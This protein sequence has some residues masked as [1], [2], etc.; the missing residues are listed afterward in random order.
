MS[1][2]VVRGA[3]GPPSY[4][5]R[6]ERRIPLSVAVLIRRRQPG[7]GGAVSDATGQLID[8]SM[9]GLRLALPGGRPFV[10][11]ELV[12]VSLTVPSEQRRNVPFSLVA[13]SARVVRAVDDTQEGVQT[14]ALAF[15]GNDLSMLSS[16]VYRS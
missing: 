12:K 11:G 4:E 14:V 15:C 6:R 10:P 3:V 1:G 2:D 5:R 9:G 13:G 8:I 7:D 16:I